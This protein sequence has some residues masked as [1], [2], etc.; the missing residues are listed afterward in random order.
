MLKVFRKMTD[1]DL[2]V[3]APIK[4]TDE[5]GQLAMGFNK[6]A[7]S[8]EETKVE[9]DRRLLEVFALYN[10]GKV[11]NTS[12]Q[13][14]KV[15]LQLVKDISKSEKID[16]IAIM[17]VDEKTSDLYIATQTGFDDKD[18]SGIRRKIGEGFYGSTAS[19]GK[20]RLVHEVDK[21]KD[22]PPEDIFSPTINSILAVPFFRRGAVLGLICAFKDKPG[23]LESSDLDLFSSVAEQLAVAIENAKSFEE[24]KMKSIQDSLTGLYNKGFFLETLEAEISKAGRFGRE[25]SIFMLDVD[26]FKHYNDTNGHP[27]GDELLIQLTQLIHN[28]VRSIDFPCRYGGEEFVV[29]LPETDKVGAAVIAEKLVKIIEAHPFPHGESQ[30]LGFVSV[31]IGLASF[32]ADSRNMDRLIKKMDEALYKGKK[33]GKNRLVVA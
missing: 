26:D 20:K 8:L 1:G 7:A 25:L 13:T 15:L 14:E 28:S 23:M 2:S 19:T 30:P 27:E 18:M 3:R 4:G 12:F 21:E 31:S 16:K 33:E 17:L 29:I 10:I 11:L 9:L 5:I 32:P 24:T 22:V 6:M